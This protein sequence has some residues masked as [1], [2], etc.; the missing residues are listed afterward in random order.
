MMR[1]ILGIL[2]LTVSFLYMGADAGA[3]SLKIAPLKYE[4]TL[5]I[6]EKK[7]GFVDIS[8]P[9][10]FAVKVNLEVQGFRQI[11]DDGTLEF[12]DSP[13][14]AQGIRLD[15]AQIM[16]QPRDAMRVYFLLDGDKLPSGD[17][18][19]AVFAS[20]EPVS[21]S[22]SQQSVRVGTLIIVTNGTPAAH[23]ADVSFID[24]SWLQ[25]GDGLSAT[26]TITN[27]EEQGAY[28]GFFPDVTVKARPYSETIARGPLLFAGRSRDIDYRQQGSYFGPILIE[29]QVNGES[30]SRLVF[31]MTGYWTWLAPLLAVF[32]FA[33]VVFF[34][35]RR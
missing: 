13:Q 16:L 17:V 9:E 25:L 12:Y 34:M 10:S 22:G 29:A 35:K 6:G 1:V 32:I 7:K 11:S 5:E 15:F 2:I 31:A 20:T 4:T 33:A 28:T 21:E 14:I 3:L 24:A 30:K 27:P 26:L 19:A 18:F 8:N 23:T